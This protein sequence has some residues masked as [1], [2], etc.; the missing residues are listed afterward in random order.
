[1]NRGAVGE[2]RDR[3]KEKGRPE[4]VMAGR[5]CSVLS[6]LQLFLYAGFAGTP[7]LQALETRPGQAIKD[8]EEEWKRLGSGLRA[9]DR[10]TKNPGRGRGSFSMA[11]WRIISRGREADAKRI[12]KQILKGKGGGGR[13]QH[14]LDIC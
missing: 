9:A 11:H 10:P 3:D 13:R 2:V 8:V 5:K 1:M 12:T 14:A 7:G 6:S 4:V